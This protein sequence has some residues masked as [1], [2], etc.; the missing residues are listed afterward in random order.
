MFNAN[1]FVDKGMKQIKDEA[2]RDFFGK[3]KEI[4]LSKTDFVK[5][6]EQEEQNEEGE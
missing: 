6:Q 1:D 4:D 5:D 3:K 2:V